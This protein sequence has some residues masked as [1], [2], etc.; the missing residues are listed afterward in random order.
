MAKSKLSKEQIEEILKRYQE[1][2]KELDL[3]TEY[4]VNIGTIRK[5]TRP[6]S[7]AKKAKQTENPILKLARELVYDQKRVLSMKEKV[8]ALEKAQNKLQ[9]EI[10]TKRQTL[11]DSI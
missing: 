4:K 7:L 10:E 11:K 2:N 5:Y 8:E 9:N 1:G 3:A 6:E